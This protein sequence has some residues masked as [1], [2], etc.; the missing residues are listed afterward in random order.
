MAETM[1]RYFRRIGGW[2]T[3]ADLAAHRSEWAEPLSTNY[4]GVDV[5]GMP[6]NSQ[7]LSTLQILSILEQFD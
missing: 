4:R 6:P 3:R 1:E 5:W 7:G 2:M